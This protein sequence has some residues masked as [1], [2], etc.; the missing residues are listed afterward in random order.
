VHGLFDGLLVQLVGKP[1]LESFT[2]LRGSYVEESRVLLP[3]EFTGF[4]L[5]ASSPFVLYLLDCMLISIKTYRH[6]DLASGNIDGL[7]RLAGTT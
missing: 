3:F 2:R 4:L 6:A 7:H 1:A 5:E